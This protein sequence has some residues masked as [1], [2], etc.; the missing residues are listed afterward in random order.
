[1][2]WSPSLPLEVQ[3]Q[4]FTSNL[5]K[6]LSWIEENLP[7]YQVALDEG[8]VHL[9]R[10]VWLPDDPSRQAK[11]PAVDAVHTHNSFHYRGLACDL[12]FYKA[13][14]Y[15]QDGSDRVFT[16]ADAFARTLDPW[17]GFG[18]SFR[19][20]NHVSLGEHREPALA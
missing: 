15:V 8:P 6:L 17:F 7:E 11:V 3:R 9:N 18:I 13:G 14:V 10:Q 4:L 1:M 12:L 20:S 2:Q 5:V 16:L 19:D